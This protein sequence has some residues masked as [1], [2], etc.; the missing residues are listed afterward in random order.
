MSIWKLLRRSRWVNI[1]DL[2]YQR[3]EYGLEYWNKRTDLAKMRVLTFFLLQHWLS[4]MDWLSAKSF[5]QY[6]KLFWLFL[7][8][9][10]FLK[11][12]ICYSII[13]TFNFYKPNIAPSCNQEHNQNLYMS[14]KWLAMVQVSKLDPLVTIQYVAIHNQ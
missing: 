13:L 8:S 11:P 6:L 1:K 10:L 2:V 14:F 5:F 12:F 7:M 4:A 9:P 3:C